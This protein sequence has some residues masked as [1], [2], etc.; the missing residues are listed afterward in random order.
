[1]PSSY[2]G[3]TLL[4]ENLLLEVES[5]TT[6]LFTAVIYVV[7]GD[8]HWTL[9]MPSLYLFDPSIYKFVCCYQASFG[10]YR[11]QSF[12]LPDFGSLRDNR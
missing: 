10:Q 7:S 5:G 1:M 11:A 8:A 12:R 4:S 9:A 6:I 3:E 2:I